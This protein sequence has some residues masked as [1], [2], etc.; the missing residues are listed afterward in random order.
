MSSKVN[1]INPEFAK[2]LGFRVHKI[3]VGAQKIDGSKLDIFDM[4]IASFLVEYKEK[5]YHFF[6][7]TFLLTDISMNITLKMLFFTLSNVKID[8]VD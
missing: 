4:V 2:K 1:V 6:K 7:K 5:K 3:K 8:L